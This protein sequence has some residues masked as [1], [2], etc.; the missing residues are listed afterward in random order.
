MTLKTSM[1]VLDPKDIVR[2]LRTDVERAGN[3]SVWAR[4]HGISRTVLN[5]VLAGKKPPTEKIIRALKLR[6]VVISSGE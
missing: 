6:W 4:K 3:Q 5:K 2:L 1:R